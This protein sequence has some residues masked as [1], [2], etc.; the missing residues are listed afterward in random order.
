MTTTKFDPRLLALA[1]CPVLLLEEAR[2]TLKKRKNHWGYDV[3]DR[4]KEDPK[5]GKK[6]LEP[7]GHIIFNPHPVI[8][9]TDD[10]VLAHEICHRLAGKEDYAIFASAVAVRDGD[11][12]FKQVLNALLDWYHENTQGHISIFLSTMLMELRENYQLEKTGDD[13][14]DKIIYLLNNEVPVSEGS[15]LLQH[16]VR[17]IIDLVVLA[18]KLCKSI[19]K[20]KISIKQAVGILVKGRP[21]KCPCD[22]AGG[23]PSIGTDGPKASSDR[24]YG[25]SPYSYNYYVATVSKYMNIINVLSELWTANKY[26]WIKQYYGEINWK[27]LPLLLLGVKV[28]LPVFRIMSKV[29]LDRKV[30]LVIDRSGSTDSIKEVIMDTA[31]IIAESLRMH[32]LPISV[33]DVGSQDDVVNSINEPLETSWFV[34]LANGGTPLGDVLSKIRGADYNSV[35]L[36]ITD[37]QPD[38]WPKLQKELAAFPGQYLTFVI[39]NDYAEYKRRINNVIPVEPHT[40]IR[41][42][43]AH[44]QYIISPGQRG[45]KASRC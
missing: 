31:V 43:L 41:S 29:K 35:L 4:K 15:S 39:G 8:S 1:N 33:L 36:I 10:L 9:C 12:L 34:P 25:D 17:D 37:G 14:M 44:E 11:Q 18:D 27:N 30:F 21:G 5:F 28:G 22:S 13:S 40:I 19:D 32:N 26:D 42:L 45:S 7:A 23:N 38:A 3:I 24:R 6:P 2:F 16:P 20:S